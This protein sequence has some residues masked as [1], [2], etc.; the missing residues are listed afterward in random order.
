MTNYDPQIKWVSINNDLEFAIK[1]REAKMPWYRQEYIEYSCR[2][3]AREI[4][5]RLKRLTSDREEVLARLYGL[6]ICLIHESRLSE[7]KSAQEER[8]DDEAFERRRAA[9][10]AAIEAANSAPSVA[11]RSTNSI[12]TSKLGKEAI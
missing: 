4:I 8:F 7:E 11:V 1:R 12:P 3:F 2:I 9:R 5:Q 10:E 6:M